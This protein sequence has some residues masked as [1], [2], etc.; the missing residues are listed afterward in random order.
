MN[1]HLK[2]W[3][4]ALRSG[5][6]YQGEGRLRSENKYCCLGVACDVL[7]DEVKGKWDSVDTFITPISTSV[8]FMSQEVLNVLDLPE[9]M[10]GNYNILVDVPK[11]LAK[12]WT[13]CDGSFVKVSVLNDT[14]QFTFEQIADAIESTYNRLKGQI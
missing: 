12:G 8:S 2:A 4:D 6:Y 7:R 14:Y 3:L 9:E 10:N 1:K 5:K 11:E 13:G